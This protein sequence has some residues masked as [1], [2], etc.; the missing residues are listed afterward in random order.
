MSPTSP[1]DPFN[2]L[3]ETLDL[4]PLKDGSL[5]GTRFTVKDNIDIA[6]HRT[7]Y[8]SPAWRAVHP[9]PVHNALCVDQLLAAG[10]RC[11]GKAIADEFTY[12]L[13]GESPFF[14]T[15]RNAKA[16]DRIPGGSSS[17]SAASVANGLADFSIGTDSGGS[18]RVPA[19]LCGIWGMRPS[20]HRISEAGVLPFMPSVS[21]VGVLASNLPLL[22]AAARVLLRS[23]TKPATPLRRLLVLSDAVEIATPAVQER[24]WA[25]LD[26]I[27]RRTGL[28]AEPIR[29]GQ[30]AGEDVPLSDCNLKALRDLQTMEVQSTIGNWIETTGPELGTTFSLAY[31]NVQGFDRIAALGSLARS[32]RFFEQI[33]AAL[34]AGT[35][36]C[37]PT[38]PTIAP[39]KGSL[40]TLEAVTAFYD[41]TMTITAF[42]G[43]AR[44]PEISAPLLTVEGCPVGLSFAAGHY[45]DEALLGALSELL[46]TQNS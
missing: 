43:V 9:A 40:D 24:L 35:I 41:P 3:V 37:F 25:A 26:D 30:I 2:A 28:A 45:Q 13:D 21:T 15:P 17:G 12:S 33:N 39:L 44:L 31:G 1:P 42:S 27:T 22:E 29:F 32:E 36:I 20:M 19:S 23:G 18:V 34:P 8:G 5:S 7:S 10:A 4:P 14:G 16:P 11:V 46:A 38:T 6:G